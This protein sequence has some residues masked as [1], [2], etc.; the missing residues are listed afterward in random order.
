MIYSMNLVRSFLLVVSGIVIADGC[1][2]SPAVNTA[3]PGPPPVIAAG[4]IYYVSD[5]SGSDANNGL[6]ASTPLKKISTAADKAVEGDTVLIMNGVYVSTSGPLLNITKSG[7]ANKYITFKAYPGHNPKVFCSGNVWNA[8]VING[9]YIVLEG[10]ELEG[11]NASITNADALASYNHKL[12]GGTDFNYYSQ[13][14]TNGITIGGPNNESKFPHHVIIRNCK[15]HDFPGGGI[16]SIQAD[17]TT[18]EGNTVYNNAW[19]MMYGGSGISILSPVSSDGV[20]TYRNIIRNNICYNNKTTIPWIGLTPPKLSDGNGIIIDVNRYPYGQTSGQ[21]YLGRTLVENNISFNNG[22]SGIHSYKAD[23][24]DIINNTAYHNGTVVGYA[25]IFS[26]NCADVKII[27]NIM[28]SASGGK[29]N[30]NSNNTNVTYDYN[31][32]FNGSVA[33]QGPHDKIADPQ[34]LNISLNGLLANF[35]LKSGS[36]AVDGG[37]QSIFSSKDI[38]GVVRPTGAG[39]DV[40]AYEK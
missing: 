37:T 35:S 19:Y 21:P 29:C 38:K 2:K 32:Y 30:S 27:N 28:Y 8:I 14:N 12:A 7:T 17:Y 39:V 40:G 23:H 9:S 1:K 5:G 33:V 4:K 18:V 22:G 15:V 20:T 10:I 3:P 13:F 25:D 31:I 6:A 34:F 24:V 36:P 26:N 11:N 16:N